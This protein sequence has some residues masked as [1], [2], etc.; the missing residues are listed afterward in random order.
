MAPTYDYNCKKCNTTIEIKRSVSELSTE[1]ICECGEARVRV[2]TAPPV[3]FTG[4]GFYST[5]N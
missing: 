1:V 3:K 2:W 4:N 5:D